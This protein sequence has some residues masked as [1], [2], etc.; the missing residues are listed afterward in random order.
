MLLGKW[1]P[2]VILITKQTFQEWVPYVIL[3]LLKTRTQEWSGYICIWTCT[4]A[5]DKG[6]DIPKSLAN[7]VPDLNPLNFTHGYIEIL[8]S[9]SKWGH[10]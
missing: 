3:M 1:Y 2:K 5:L 7:V 9:E 6:N 4:F 8:L 10:K